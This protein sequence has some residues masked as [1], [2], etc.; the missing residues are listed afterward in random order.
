MKEI[1]K[2]CPCPW[3]KTTPKL[4]MNLEDSTWIPYLR[5]ENPNCSVN[6]KSK[7][8]SIRKN[9]K[10]H[11]PDLHSKMKNMINAWNAQNPIDAKEGFVFDFKELIKNEIA[12]RDKV[13]PQ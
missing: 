13:L 12:E 2:V 7:H 11:L 4:I 6:P 3:C 9:Q 8:V 10:Y 5:C 1:M